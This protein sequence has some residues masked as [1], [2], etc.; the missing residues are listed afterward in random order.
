MPPRN[1]RLVN[2]SDP[3]SA[4]RYV[5]EKHGYTPVPKSEKFETFVHDMAAIG[6]FE[7]ERK[8]DGF[9][10][11]LPSSL[12]HMVSFATLS[13]QEG[14]LP[15]VF[16][17]LAEGKGEG[18]KLIPTSGRIVPLDNFQAYIGKE[19]PAQFFGCDGAAPQEAIVAPSAAGAGAYDDVDTIMAVDFLK[20]S[21]YAP[22][23]NI[24]ELQSLAE[25]VA[26]QRQ[27]KVDGQ[28]LGFSSRIDDRHV[29]S[30]AL[31]KFV[32]ETSSRVMILS[33]LGKGRADPIE[34]QENGVCDT[35]EEF[36]QTLGQVTPADYFLF[37]YGQSPSHVRQESCVGRDRLNF[38][39]RRRTASRTTP[40]H[41]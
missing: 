6:G 7:L 25:D 21:G 24:G 18:L 9:A 35:L 1:P 19:S 28:V 22:A 4:I 27:K 14:P 30:I 36:C 37:T 13:R 29:H 17:M 31:A 11:R 38:G 10:G 33:M 34:M 5:M 16:S 41:V 23:N 3:G 39:P 15:V 26:D 40:H 32:D 20:K 2:D 12:L 8:V